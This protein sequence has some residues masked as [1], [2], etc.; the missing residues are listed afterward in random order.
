MSR[1]ALLLPGNK[2]PEYIPPRLPDGGGPDRR[3]Q[4]VAGRAPAKPLSG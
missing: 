3:G 1:C 4:S 2:Y